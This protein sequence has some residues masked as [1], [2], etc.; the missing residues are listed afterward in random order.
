MILLVII[1]VDF[2]ILHLKSF[3]E[4]LLF[5]WLSNRY[6]CESSKQVSTIAVPWA[7]S[8]NRRWCSDHCFWACC[9]FCWMSKTNWWHW[10]SDAHITFCGFI[11]T[12][13]CLIPDVS[14][15]W[16]FVFQHQNV[17]NCNCWLWKDVHDYY[18]MIM[19][20]T[21]VNC[22]ECLIMCILYTVCFSS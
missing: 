12:D 15:S 5:C 6:L 22:V 13:S 20:I 21:A 2:H 8:A 19:I 7:W 16:T 17:L 14:L 11:N 9:P 10:N 4:D 18:F 1:S 3:V